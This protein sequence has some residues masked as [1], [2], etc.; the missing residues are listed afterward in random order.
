MDLLITLIGNAAVDPGFRKLFLDNPLETADYYGFRMTKGDFQIM[1]AMFAKL[2]NEERAALEAAFT[3]VEVLLYAK[4][5]DA[6]L[7]PPF[8]KAPCTK[9]CSLSLYPPREL[10]QLREIIAKQMEAA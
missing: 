5:D 7:A 4:V 10:P 2:S 6:A 9:P 3:A 1:T 8:K